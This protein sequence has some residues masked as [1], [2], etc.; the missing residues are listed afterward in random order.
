MADRELYLSRINDYVR[1]DFTLEKKYFHVN[2]AVKDKVDDLNCFK[3]FFGDTVVFDLKRKDKVWFS[4]VISRLYDEI[5]ECFCERL[6]DSKLHVTLHDLSNGT[7]YYEVAQKVNSNY[8][9]L[10]ELLKMVNISPKE[11]KMKT[12]YI[13]NIL[14][15]S[16]GYVLVPANDKEYSKLLT[17]YQLF[18][19]ILKLNYEY[20]P[21]VTL[22]YFN[23]NGFDIESVNKL[24]NL[25]RE[26]NKEEHEFVLSTDKLFYQYFKSM[27]DFEN[28]RKIVK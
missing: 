2:K 25:V 10:K 7:D 23:V 4:S 20:T 14:N 24:E 28:V 15:I 5:P 13:A 12:R 3:P 11:I 8:K 19:S 16:L 21:H 27:N 17:L 26:L 1:P 6:E 18:D 22:G 9:Q